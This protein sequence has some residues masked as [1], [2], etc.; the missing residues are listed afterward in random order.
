MQGFT[1]G[2]FADRFVKGSE[3]LAKWLQE[4]KLKYDETIK[5]GFDNIPNAFLNLFEG[6]NIGKLLVKVND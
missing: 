6:N 1:V 3:A 2:D 4:G 5:E